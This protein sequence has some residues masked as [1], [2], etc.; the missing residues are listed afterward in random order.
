MQAAKQPARRSS[1]V[2]TWLFVILTAVA[3]NL[4]LF[5]TV[6]ISGSSMEPTLHHGERALVPR[7]ELWWKRLTGG[8]WERGNIVFFPD[9]QADCHL[10][11][12]WVIK[13]IVG[14]PGETVAIR[15]GVVLINGAEL[16]EPYLA[17]EWP[18]SFVMAEITVP[19][20]SFFVLGDNRYPY[21]AHDS[22]SYGPVDADSI[23]GR[24]SAVLWPPFRS[25][26]GLSLN[27]RPL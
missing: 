2:L 26:D 27:W 23:G 21:G 20:G 19:D 24:A 14:L 18:G 3:V 11:C 8:S 5:T 6:G 12:P 10:R 4:F 17:G 15:Q 1:P 9:P 13:R 16:S 22:R 25:A 7:F